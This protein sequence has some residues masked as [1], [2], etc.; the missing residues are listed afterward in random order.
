MIF[1]STSPRLVSTPSVFLHFFIFLTTYISSFSPVFR[2]RSVS[3]LCVAP[4]GAKPKSIFAMK[5]G[6]LV[7]GYC[8]DDARVPQ[9]YTLPFLHIVLH[10]L[11]MF[12]WCGYSCSVLLCGMYIYIR[13]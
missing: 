3:Q 2:V 8:G 11:V 12:L 9:R 1:I 4:F 10:P 6:I 7:G 5:S 13:S